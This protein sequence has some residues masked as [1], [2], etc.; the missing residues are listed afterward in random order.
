LLVTPTAP[1]TPT[2]DFAAYTVTFDGKPLVAGE[3]IEVA[4]GV[5]LTR[6]C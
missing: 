5:K 1:G 2:R 6:R 3:R 4:P